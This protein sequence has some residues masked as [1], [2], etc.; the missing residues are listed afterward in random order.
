VFF[1]Q[2]VL[3]QGEARMGLQTRERVSRSS[4]RLHVPDQEEEPRKTSVVTKPRR[5]ICMLL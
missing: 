4:A 3:R 5:V 1:L 2:E